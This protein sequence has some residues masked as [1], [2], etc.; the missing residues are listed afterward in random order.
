VEIAKHQMMIQKQAVQTAINRVWESLKIE[1][2]PDHW[3]FYDEL[4]KEME[5]LREAEKELLQMSAKRRTWLDQVL[6]KVYYWSVK[7]RFE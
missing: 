1:S 4:K 5:V 3:R 2:G 7:E 6:L